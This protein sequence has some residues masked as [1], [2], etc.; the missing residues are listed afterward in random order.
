MAFSIV[1]TGKSEV[2]VFVRPSKAP[3]D[4]FPV[5][6]GGFSLMVDREGIASAVA[7]SATHGGMCVSETEPPG[8]STIEQENLATEG[9]IPLV[10]GETG[11]A[12]EPLSRF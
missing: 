12:T 4:R 11:Q 9:P 1:K 8:T 7:C 10:E 5:W 2:T 6:Q 3:A